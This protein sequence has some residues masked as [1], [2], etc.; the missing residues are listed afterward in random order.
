METVA[1]FY[2]EASAIATG[3]R[4]AAGSRG[5]GEDRSGIAAHGLPGEDVGGAGAACEED[6]RI[7]GAARA[8]RVGDGLG[9]DARGFVEDFADGEAA[10]AREVD[11]ADWAAGVESV[12]R[13]EVG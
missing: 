8:D 11:D 4:L 1:H 2:R 5:V 7:A 3:F 13:G 10:A 6:G 12:D 9:Q